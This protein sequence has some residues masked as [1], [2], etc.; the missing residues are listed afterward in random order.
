MV[1]SGTLLSYS[2]LVVGLSGYWA[3]WAEQYL[4]ILFWT[5]GAEPSLPPL[6][7]DSVV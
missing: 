6:R 7:Y 4:G 5:G 2:T 1:E 3:S